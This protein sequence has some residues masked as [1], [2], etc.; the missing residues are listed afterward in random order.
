MKYTTW[1]DAQHLKEKSEVGDFEKAVECLHQQNVIVH[2]KEDKQASDLVV[3]DP[4]WLVQCL[5]KVITVPQPGNWA[6]HQAVVWNN[7][8]TKGTLTLQHLLT[9]VLP[10]HEKES[11]N[12]IRIM[13]LTG[14]I[15]NWNDEIYL[16]PA[17][18]KS[19]MTRK[20]IERC[21]KKLLL[22]SLYVNFES[23][24]IPIGLFTR[25]QV[26]F[27]GWCKGCVHVSTLIKYLPCTTN[28][29]E[30]FICKFFT[31]GISTYETCTWNW[32]LFTYEISTY[33]F[34]TYETYNL[35]TATFSYMKFSYMKCN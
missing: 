33:E 12:L 17:M 11:Q 19:K 15:C 10:D 25:F 35:L 27:I 23:G 8:T 21:L 30:N 2:F 22:P 20:D 18:V 26:E 16:V 29:Y 31:Y 6:G 13:E 28:P 5:S 4:N 14:L 1:E 24:H 32:N 3:L 7:L 9:K 34:P